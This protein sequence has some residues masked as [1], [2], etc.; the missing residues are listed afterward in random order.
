M[1]NQCADNINVTNDRLKEIGSILAK[2]IYRLKQREAKECKNTVYEP[3]LNERMQKS[4]C[5]LTKPN[6]NVRE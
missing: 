6:R 4:N 1:K 3:I 5:L 2:G